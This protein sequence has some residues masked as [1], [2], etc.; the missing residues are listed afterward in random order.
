MIDWKNFDKSRLFKSKLSMLG[1][2]GMSLIIVILL[3]MT[4]LKG[5]AEKEVTSNTLAREV[6]IKTTSEAITTDDM[7]RQTVKE[8]MQEETQKMRG[9]ID[10]L[11]QD[12]NIFK[13]TQK[14]SVN[15]N[16]RDLYSKIESMSARIEVLQSELQKNSEAT[17]RPQEI[18]A[19]N[20]N[21]F[22]LGLENSK[23]SFNYKP[24]KTSD[25]YIPAGSFAKAVLLSGVDASTSLASNANP[26]P[27]LIR[28]TDHGTLPRRFK[29]DLKDCHVIAAAYGDLSSERAKLRLE[30][31]S[32]TE[33][34][35]GEIIETEVIG[36]VAGE[37]G[38]QGLRGTV[39]S[40]EGKLLG[41]SL[42]S[43]VL[44][45]LAGNFSSNNDRAVSLFA[46][47]KKEPVSDKLKNSM[48]EGTS[49]SLDRLSKY[50]IERAEALQPIVQVGSGRKIDVIFTEG[51]FFG[52][53]SLK[54]ELAKKRD[55]KIKDESKNQ[56]AGLIRPLGD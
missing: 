21:Q 40:T 32:C 46:S 16:L 52:T 37:D 12:M 30:K 53:T 20:I 48:V 28:I 19:K 56:N 23:N 18:H 50:Y 1:I 14:T 13:E 25:N 36:F 55:E 43:G 45:G 39:V 27:V 42:L 15:D 5:R 51:V 3:I 9:K 49:S 10:N 24:I 4:F 31:L 54:Q 41:N 2:G 11:S 44:G 7:W 33:I 35:T 34:K 47:N 8:K 26:E 38:R 6:T 17:L 22:T 29:S